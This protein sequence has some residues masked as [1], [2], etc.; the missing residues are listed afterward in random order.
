[1]MGVSGRTT[2]FPSKSNFSSIWGALELNIV[3]LSRKM[4]EETVE[5]WSIL[6]WARKRQL[7][8]TRRAF[9]F[10]GYYKF[11]DPKENF[12]YAHEHCGFTTNDDWS[13]GTY[14]KYASLD[15]ELEGFH[16]YLAYIRFGIGRTT[17]DAAHEIRDGKIERDEGI[18]LVKRYDGEFPKKYFETF[19]EFRGINDDDF[20]EVIDSWRSDHIWEKRG[21]GWKLRHPIWTWSCLFLSRNAKAT[22][23]IS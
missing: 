5:Y 13:E 16:Y 8:G 3:L 23:N 19:K 14:S 22:I 18:A 15:D 1:M 11:W 6:S 12:Y 9:Q 20:W 21:N 17:S 7:R 2:E 10:F 4:L